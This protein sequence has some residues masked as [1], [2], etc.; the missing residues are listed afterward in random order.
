MVLH[1]G[2]GLEGQ[3]AEAVGG[4]PE[5]GGRGGQL[6]RGDLGG[7]E[8]GSLEMRAG[9]GFLS[10]AGSPC[11]QDRPWWPLLF[12]Q[13]QPQAHPEDCGDDCQLSLPVESSQDLL[14]PLQVF[15]SLL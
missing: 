8:W 2:D 14:I 11:S 3:Q 1:V 9:V 12:Q 5:G 4:G 15:L 6:V 13:I 7:P 10:S